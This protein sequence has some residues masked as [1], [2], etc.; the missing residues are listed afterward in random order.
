MKNYI[1]YAANI[2]LHFFKAQL[3]ARSHDDQGQ[4]IYGTFWTIRMDRRYRSRMPG[5]H[6]S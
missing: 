5:V 4:L 3:D 2:V 1:Y 6:S